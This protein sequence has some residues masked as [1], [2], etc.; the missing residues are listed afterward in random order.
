MSDLYEG[1]ALSN[2]SLLGRVTNEGM[3]LSE[4]EDDYRLCWRSY[5][6]KV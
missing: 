3:N 6:E 4:R 5:K 2:P 1:E